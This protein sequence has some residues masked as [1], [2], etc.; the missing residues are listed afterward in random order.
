[1]SSGFHLFRIAGIDVRIDWSLLII[2]F[3]IFNSLALG[4][5][6]AWHPDWA[7]GLTWPHRAGCRAAVLRLRARS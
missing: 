6:P 3:L 7:P 5:F 2:F 4:L 1:M